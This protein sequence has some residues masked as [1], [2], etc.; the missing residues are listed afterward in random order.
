M[1]TLVFAHDLP[2]VVSETFRVLKPGGRVA[3]NEY[4]HKFPTIPFGKQLLYDVYE[5][6]GMAL[7]RPFGV[8]KEVLEQAGFVD[9][10]VD[11]ITVN[12]RPLAVVFFLLGIIPSLIVMA[13]GLRRRYPNTMTA[14]LT[15]FL[16]WEDCFRYVTITAK[17]PGVFTDQK[18]K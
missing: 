18:T 8:W 13:L 6:S 4:E 1:E 2:K 15:P 9:V 10:K 14:A 17:K 3:L 5:S 16:Y 7:D 12:I 11:D